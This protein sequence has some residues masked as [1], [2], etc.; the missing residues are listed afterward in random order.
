[1]KRFISL[2]LAVVAINMLSAQ[3]IS[4]RPEIFT[5]K[6]G[7]T[8]YLNP[9]PDASTVFGLVAVKAGGKNDP[10][11]A[12]GLAH[13]QEHML[14]K[15]TTELGTTNWDLEKIH[16]DNIF[17]LYDNL[18]QTKDES[19]R[20]KIQQQ[21]NKESLEANKYVIPNELDKLLKSIG[22]TG[23]NAFTST[24]MTVYFNEFP[25]TQ[26]EKWLEIYSHRFINPVFRGFQ[27]ELEVVY[28][29]FNMYNDMFV[30]PLLEAFSKSFFKNHP[31]GQQ[32]I[33]GTLEHL[34]NPSLTKMYQFFKTWYV[35]NNMALI[36]S[37]NFNT[38]EIRP[39]IEQYFSRWERQ[40]VPDF[41]VYEEKPFSGRELVKVKMSPVKLGILGF[42][43]IPAKHPDKYTM[44]VLFRLLSNSNQTGFLDQLMIDNKLMAVQAIP[45][46]QKDHGGLYILIL[47][48]IIGQSLENAEELIL[49]ELKKLKEGQFD[50]EM[51]E[52]IK[53]ELYIEFVTSLESHSNVCVALAQSF[54]NEESVD[55]MISY[56][57]RIMRVTRED[58]ISAANKYF[59][60]DYLAFF[61]TMGFPKKV[62]IDKP[63][64]E[65]LVDTLGLQ[66]DYYR[67]LTEWEPARTYFN[68]AGYHEFVEKYGLTN[69]TT[70][71]FHENKFNNIFTLRMRYY[72]S[73]A[74]DPLTELAVEAMNLAG[75][76]TRTVKQLKS[77]FAALGVS[78]S[79]GY[80]GDY[81]EIK[82]QGIEEGLQESLF[83]LN[84][85]LSNPI[86]E[87][88]KINVL[89]EN[90][91]GGRKF[92]SADADG[93]ADMLYEYIVYGKYSSYKNRKKLKEIQ[94]L[95]PEELINL[96]LTYMQKHSEIHFTGSKNSIVIITENRHELFY[97]ERPKQIKRRYE[98]PKTAEKQ[99]KVIFVHKPNTVQSKI[100]FYTLGNEYTPKEESV[101]DMFN[102][103]FGGGFSGLVLKEI[104][105]FRSMAYAA[106]ATFSLPLNLNSKYTFTGYIGT[107]ADKTIEAIDIFMNLTR[108]MP[109]KPEEAEMIKKYLILSQYSKKPHFRNVTTQYVSDTFRGWTTDPLHAKISTY[110]ELE[111]SDI[112]AFYNS[113]L[114]NKPVVIMVVADKK[115]IKPNELS[116]YGK[117]EVVKMK[118]LYTK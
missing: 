33:I 82:L 49:Q 102:A 58:I 75:T 45:M 97:T 79:F 78:Y 94:K 84:N 26:M 59:G 106:G 1:M 34:K 52:A 113:H 50:A 40:S 99:N 95:K 108:N 36:I 83:L 25:P 86:L 101:S 22:S 77:D 17:K 29:E 6:N 90:I 8:V 72:F 38:G 104:R 61:S 35:P 56:P 87:K 109:E 28:E 62:K 115:R 13:Y 81:M 14:F 51:I 30:M 20:K 63:G 53:K 118:D 21:I 48:K 100:Y 117:I 71:Y 112:L 107:Q 37:G 11:D 73:E 60:N 105:E 7:L 114:K 64:Y 18:A 12:T 91:K 65:P 92:E 85:L 41:P 5:L 110:P 3:S 68:F 27:A 2:M 15:G 80:H 10:A 32:S 116:K 93:V 46:P 44:D 47:P 42:R 57:D 19:E 16:I 89:Y 4:F 23:L 111:F 43:T 98:L 39:L 55:E 88:S 66:S 69:G 96:F 31:Y 74:P 76:A 9:D 67:Q 70:I 24:D 54:V 103:Y